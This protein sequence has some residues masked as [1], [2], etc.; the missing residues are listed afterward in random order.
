MI[1]IVTMINLY[2]ISVHGVFVHADSCSVFSPH[3]QLGLWPLT[4]KWTRL[5][6]CCPRGPTS[7]LLQME[8]E[9]VA[10]DV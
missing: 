9:L 8:G 3:A 10:R 6:P 7:G 1:I 4:S 2:K 5:Q